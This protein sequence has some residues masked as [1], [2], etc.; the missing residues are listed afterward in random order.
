MLVLPSF[1]WPD[2]RIL[3]IL[4]TLNPSWDLTCCCH[5]IWWGLLMKQKRSCQ[6]GFIV[7]ATI[8]FMD[9]DPVL[10][11]ILS[12]IFPRIWIIK[13]FWVSSAPCSRIIGIIWRNHLSNCLC[14]HIDLLHL[15]FGVFMPVVIHRSKGLQQNLCQSTEH[16]LIA[17]DDIHNISMI[18]CFV[19]SRNAKKTQ[20][21]KSILNL[22]L[23]CM[24]WKSKNSKVPTVKIIFS[25]IYFVNTTCFDEWF[26]FHVKTGRNFLKVNG[27][28][29]ALFNHLV[30]TFFKIR[31]WKKV[32]TIKQ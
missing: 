17:F 18:L 12:I 29:E 14:Q 9:G 32:S 26:L 28:S 11:I 19:Y 4:W 30:V 21:D 27:Y 24:K 8:S 1:H 7:K 20:T 31:V 2:C 22:F 6:I 13:I 3:K 16:C 23:T 5:W 10:S 25:K 15:A